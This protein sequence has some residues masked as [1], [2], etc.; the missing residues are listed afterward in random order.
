MELRYRQENEGYQLVL[1]TVYS[2][3]VVPL[4]RYVNGKAVILHHCY[5]CNQEF[6]ARPSWLVYREDQKHLCH[7]KYGDICGKRYDYSNSVVA[8]KLTDAEK[9]DILTL[10]SQGK[11]VSELARKYS[12]KPAAI[13]YQLKKHGVI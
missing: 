3:S 12:V 11:S 9:K 1:D 8:K 13:R 5:S 7:V 2:G 4:Q 10:A 6:Y